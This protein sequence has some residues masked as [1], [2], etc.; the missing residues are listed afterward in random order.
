MK[1]WFV[2]FKLVSY[3]VVLL[4]VGAICYGGIIALTYWSGIGV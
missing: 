4:M 1:A 3:A 2:P